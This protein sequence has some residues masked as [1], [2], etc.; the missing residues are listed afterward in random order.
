MCLDLDLRMLS[1]RG[2]GIKGLGEGRGGE[3]GE[4]RGGE[5]R[6]GEG[7]GCQQDPELLVTLT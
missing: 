5:G 6:G 4:G 2:R 7:G 3:G 1:Q